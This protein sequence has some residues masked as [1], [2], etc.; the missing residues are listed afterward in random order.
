[1][2]VE[3]WL[4]R[5]FTE[6]SEVSCLRLPVDFVIWRLTLND[7]WIL[8]ISEDWRPWCMRVY[9]SVVH[10]KQMDCMWVCVFLLYPD[11]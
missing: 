2:F 1:M 10:V 7:R 3:L 8:I 5:E 9:I 4:Y 11:N 6:V